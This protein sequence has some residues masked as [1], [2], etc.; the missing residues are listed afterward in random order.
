MRSHSNIQINSRLLPILVG[1]IIIM[2]LIDDSK[3]WVTLLMGLGGVWLI[4]Y[5][6][7]RSLVSNIRLTREIRYGWVQV[8]DRLEERFTL[9]NNGVAPAIWVEVK[10]QST[11]PG[12]I[13][14]RVT[15]VEGHGR[16]QWRTQSI[17][18]QRGLYT[19]GLTSI[20]TG[21]PFGVYT[22]NL[23][24][25]AS[26]TLV[27]MPPIVPLPRIDVAPGGRTGEGRPRANAPERTVSA[28]SVREYFPGDSLRLIH[29]RTFARR[30]VPYVR[31]LDGTPSGD[32]WIILDLDQNVQAGHGWD[33]TVE[34][35]VILAASLA[36]QG[37]RLRRAV[38][39]I[40]NGKDLDW[41]SPQQGEG[42]RWIILRSLALVGTGDRSLGELLKHTQPSIQ[43]RSSLIVITPSLNSDWIETLIPLLWRDVVVTVLLLDP[44]SFDM[45]AA[46]TG[47]T[48]KIATTL[49]GLGVTRYVIT[50]DL[51]NRPEARP[52]HEGQWEWRI[53]PRGR[54][55]PVRKP[56]NMAWKVLS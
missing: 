2:Q 37:L 49:S 20:R 54:A 5:L 50:R 26:T 13:I 22:V 25:P 28:G 48:N 38:G 46:I 14:N 3:I 11:M 19:L 7:A 56:G 32:W 52:G 9:T 51:L 44:A 23:T 21:D 43:H 53:S 27:V 34:H 24:N 35:G 15:G 6:W 31:I 1:A 12:Y 33:S 47:N 4:S 18:N 10:D 36:D 16:N 17:C 42:Q 39:L 30:E 8:G 55:V 40:A 29:W 45:T 41:I